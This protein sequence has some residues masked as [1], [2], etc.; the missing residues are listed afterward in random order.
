MKV[1]V[2]T[3]VYVNESNN[4]LPLLK[5]AI[6]SIKDQNFFSYEHIIV[7]D[8]STDDL[9]GF[10]GDLDDNNIRYFYKPNTGI[11]LSTET[12]NMGFL[13]AKGEY[14][15]IL[16]SDDEQCPN[17]LL[18][19]SNYLDQNTEDVA[20]L[21]MANYIDENNV[22]RKFLPDW[23]DAA[24]E[25]I[26]RGNFVNGCAIM[27]RRSL[28]KKGMRL[29]PN[30]TSFCADYDMWV[31]VS[32][33]GEIGRLEDEVVNYYNHSDATRNKTRHKT[34]AHG[35]LLAP[36]EHYPFRKEARL[37]YVKTSALVRRCE[38]INKSDTVTFV[39]H[40]FSSPRASSNI[41]IDYNQK[42][43]TEI[44]IQFFV[45]QKFYDQDLRMKSEILLPDE[46]KALANCTSPIA[47]EGCRANAALIT[48]LSVVNKPITLI[49]QQGDINLRWIQHI[50]WAVVDC[51]I[52][53][54]NREREK[55]AKLLG[56]GTHIRH[57]IDNQV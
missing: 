8:G 7:D 45:A 46:I 29:P 30:I 34:A 10:I 2:I 41:S 44:G 42:I 5:R 52:Y 13:K 33:Y 20:V 6:K 39:S 35:F 25:L 17:A 48:R 32:E 51:I 36:E 49:Y 57:V 22:C 56:L 40:R 31:R 27:F 1:S 50:D 4:R 38:S 54:S 55:I 37:R 14:L 18:S 26:T 3:Y 16:S 24:D 21:G 28:F 15:I 11:T 9:K 12:Y 23:D 53:S 43:E 19:M 47:I